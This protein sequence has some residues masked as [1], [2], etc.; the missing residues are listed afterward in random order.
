MLKI[1]KYLKFKEWLLILVNIALIAG[2]VWLDL[3]LPE[4]MSEIT[5]L[6]ETP[7]SDIREIWQAGG[8][9]LLCALSSALLSVI[10]EFFVAKIA[11]GLSK[12]LREKIFDKV[13]SFSQDE[14]NKF[15]T[16]SLITRSTNDVAQVQGSIAMGLQVMIMAPILATWAIIKILGKSWQWSAVTAIAVLLLV[17]MITAIML[18]AIPKFKKTQIYTDNLNRVTR[19]NLTGLR[20]VRAYNAEK[21]EIQKFEKANSNLTNLHLF[22]YKTLA[23]MSPG[24]SL[25]MS[26]LSLSIYLIGAYLISATSLLNRLTVFSDMVVFS[27]YAMQVVMAFIMLTMIFLMLPRAIVS[28]KRIN[29]VLSTKNKIVDGKSDGTSNLV[30]EIEFKYVGFKYP[31]ADEYVLKN[32]SFT[33][34]KGETVAFIGSTGSGKSTLIN[35]VPRFY[36]A[37]E[38]SVFID[39]IDVR[40]YKLFDLHNKIGFVSQKAVLF[41][42]TVES[43]VAFGDNSLGTPSEEEIANALQIA[44]AKTF[45]EKMEEKYKSHI[46]QGGTNVSGGQKQRLSI[47]RAI[48]RKPEI[49]IFDDS[50]SALDYKTDKKLRHTLNKTL[51]NTTWLIV[52]QRIGTIMNADKIIVLDNGEIVGVGTHSE[53]LNNCKVYSEIAHSQLSKEELI[54]G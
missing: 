8:Y 14:I 13:Q 40:N 24:M 25:I 53:L 51:F 16:A 39:N 45:V 38:G 43:N 15:S 32:I 2:Q 50:F 34:H 1:L 23:L 42:G 10:V 9:M 20:V 7:N 48:A 21:F 36:D 44:Q 6:I 3:K 46:S 17:I 33:A 11:A 31:D 5:K 27:S 35:L 22:I 26:G 47:A 19:E 37:T 54:D 12:R 28:A 30:G 52:A 29:E 4:Y 41:S 18:T 49:L